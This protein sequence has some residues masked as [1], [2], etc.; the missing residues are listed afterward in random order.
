MKTAVGIIVMK[1]KI[2]IVLVL[3][4]GLTFLTLNAYA[5]KERVIWL[6]E[7]NGISQQ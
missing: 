5:W 3:A 4:V 7:I 6:K 2:G 1:T